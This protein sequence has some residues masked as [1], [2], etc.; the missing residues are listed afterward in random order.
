M[1]NTVPM[2]EA[3]ASMVDATDAM[4]PETAFKMSVSAVL[5]LAT[6]VISRMKVHLVVYQAVECVNKSRT[7]VSRSEIHR[8]T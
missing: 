1:T 3:L 5:R 4:I 2:T 7:R 8:A 6:V